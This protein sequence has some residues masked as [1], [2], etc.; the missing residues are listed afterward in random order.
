MSKKDIRKEPTWRLAL[1]FGV[2]FIIVVIIIQAIWEFFASG[3][4]NAVTESIDNGQWVS[5]VISKIVLGVVYG[6]TMAYF[7][8][9]NAKK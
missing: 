4:L 2:I 5:Y 9:K 8:K 3:N 7:T 1:R 6:F